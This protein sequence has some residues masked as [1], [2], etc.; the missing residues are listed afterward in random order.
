MN[1]L[2]LF[3]FAVSSVII[4][5]FIL[6]RQKN[7]ALPVQEDPMALSYKARKV[8][9]PSFNYIPGRTT[10]DEKSK[11]YVTDW[12]YEWEYKGKKHN[13]MF[14]DNPNSQYEHYLTVFP[15]EI[16]ITIHKE[17]GKYYVSR[18]VRAQKRQNLRT[19]LISAILGWIISGILV[20]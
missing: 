13:M 12:K 18:T 14:C 6:T 5:A 1:I 17:T 11:R 4:E 20:R 16:D 19:L 10:Y 9:E 7:K 15:D 8:D 2:R 3:V